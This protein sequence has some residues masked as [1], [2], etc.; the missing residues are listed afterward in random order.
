MW[1]L[2]ECFC[3]NRNIM[4]CKFAEYSSCRDRLFVLIETL[5]NVNDFPATDYITAVAV[6][7]ETLWNVNSRSD[8]LKHRLTTVLIETLWNVNMTSEIPGIKKME[9]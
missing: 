5:W 3:I 8:S 9:Y 7:I 6:L 2:Q 4:E 1:I